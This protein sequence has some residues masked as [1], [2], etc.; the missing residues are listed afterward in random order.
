MITRIG[1]IVVIAI[2]VLLAAIGLLAFPTAVATLWGV[3]VLLV[4]PGVAVVVHKAHPAD[5]PRNAQRV[6]LRA[7]TV[8]AAATMATAAIA[9]GLIVLSPTITVLLVAALG[10]GAAIWVIRQRGTGHSVREHLRAAVAR[11]H[12]ADVAKSPD[13]GSRALEQQAR[14]LRIVVSEMP[15]PH[16]CAV[17]QH[18][19]WQLI[20]LPPGPPRAEMAGIRHA[21]LDEL[22]RRDPAGFGRWLDTQPRAGSDPGRFLTVNH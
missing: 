14:P 9:A 2:G 20:S 6:A 7:G 18:S 15:T 10:A 13:T 17:W 3:A 11:V 19:Y 5:A 16:L 8:A 21:V 22:E 12:P 1:Q 4:G